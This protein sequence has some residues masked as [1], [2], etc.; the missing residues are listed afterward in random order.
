MVRSRSQ[1]TERRSASRD[2]IARVWQ[3]IT[4]QAPPPEHDI[5]EEE[6]AAFTVL[7]E[8]PPGDKE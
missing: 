1:S 3:K 8:R 6:P 2:R 4:H 7:N 5:A